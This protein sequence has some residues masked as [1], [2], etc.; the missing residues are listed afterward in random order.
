VN[1]DTTSSAR[2]LE[3]PPLH[4]KNYLIAVGISLA[5]LIL[6]I[7][8]LWRYLSHPKAIL[9]MLMGFG[10]VLS[11]MLLVDRRNKSGRHTASVWFVV[12]FLALSA[13]FAVL[14]P[15]SL[16]HTLNGGSD[17]E[18]ALRLCVVA[19]RH[20]QYPYAQH[21][22]LG[23]PITPLP[24]AIYLSEPFYVLG[25]IAWQNFLW[26]AAFFLFAIKYFR[27]RTTALSFLAIFLLF[28]PADLSDFTSGGDYIANFAYVAVAI[29]IFAWSLKRPGIYSVLAAMFLGFTLSSRIVYVFVLPPLCALALRQIS[30]ARTLLLFGV[31]M[32]TAAAVTLPI[33][34][35]HPLVN[36]THQLNQQSDKLKYLPG[37][38]HW[39]YVLPLLALCAGC[40][41][42]LIRMNLP[43]LFGVFSFASLLIIAPPVL[44]L[45]VHEGRPVYDISYLAIS[46]L[47]FALWGMSRLEELPHGWRPHH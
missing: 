20:H 31:V 40:G 27:Y 22:Y 32:A 43:R 8:P 13:A 6:A 11:A 28:S 29:G 44:S 14:Y 39:N 3:P 37:S 7:H 5:W 46:I 17:R 21:T 1:V 34:L 12:L 41:A 18:D 9:A 26:Y 33:F 45:A 35:P 38:L 23:H 16:R 42:F 10:V 47:S 30:R 4:G 19:L 15:I 2:L 36:L 25:H 24:G